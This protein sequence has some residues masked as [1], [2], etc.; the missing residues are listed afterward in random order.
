MR[1]QPTDRVSPVSQYVNVP[2]PSTV[3]ER[4]E[5]SP[6]EPASQKQGPGESSLGQGGNCTEG[7]STEGPSTRELPTPHPTAS[8]S[9]TPTPT[10][11]TYPRTPPPPPMGYTPPLL[12][13][14]LCKGC[15]TPI[16]IGEY[17]W[18]EVCVPVCSMCSAFLCG[19]CSPPCVPYRVQGHNHTQKDPGWSGSRAHIQGRQLWH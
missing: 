4:P 19:V 12:V 11:H 13:M 10:P 15:H 6:R 16:R 7:A 5:P 2:N 18:S 3:N 14:Y 1:T 17:M 8:P 9:S